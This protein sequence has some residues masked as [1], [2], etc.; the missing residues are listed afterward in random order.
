MPSAAP[1]KIP[2]RLRSSAQKER[3]R[4]QAKLTKITLPARGAGG[5]DARPQ[6]FDVG[7]LGVC[8]HDPGPTER[9]LVENG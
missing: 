9:R 3:R 7:V 5:R 8:N 1:K 4:G 2:I 6:R